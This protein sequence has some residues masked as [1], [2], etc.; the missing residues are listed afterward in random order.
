MTA[1]GLFPSQAVA[2]GFDHLIW[3]GKGYIIDATVVT[4]PFSA[5]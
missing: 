5:P 4:D 2:F 1:A 3:N